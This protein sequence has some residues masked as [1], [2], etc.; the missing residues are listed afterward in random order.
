MADNIRIVGNIVNTSTVSRYSF[1]D[2]NLVTTQTIQE[3]FGGTDD[4]IE[5]YVEDVGGNVLTIDYNYLSYKLPSNVGLTPGVSSFPNTRGSIQT[6]DVGVDSTLSSNTSSLYPIIEIDPVKDVQFLGYSSGEF[7]L[8]YNFFQNILSNPTD[9]ALFVK[10]ISQ[11]RTEIRLASTSLTNDEIELVAD[12]IINEI[13]TSP[14]II[15]HLLNFGDNIQY[16]AINAALNKEATG[17]ELLFKLYQPLPLSVQEKQTLWI[18]KEKTSPYN[19]DV[20]LDK[21]VTPPPPP[22]LRG[23]NFNIPI[24]NQGTISTSYG[25][26]SNLISSL[27]A[28]QSSSYNQIQ[29]LLATQSIDINVDYTDFDNFVFFSSAKQRVVN[30]YTKVKEIED[31]QNFINRYK[32]FVAT[33]A[34]LQTNINQYSSS[35]NNVISNF[36]GYEYYLYFGN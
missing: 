18:V 32:Q 17:F 1:E 25:N 10:E 9:R 28:L 36:D 22:T 30:F 3:N 33:T 29:S 34:S 8:K 23:P 27:Q 15:E 21:I 24:E 26:Y 35:I 20:N 14:Y 4:Y 31:Y 7:I 12:T 16:L 6:A 5:F 2:I 11:D 13:N 19:F